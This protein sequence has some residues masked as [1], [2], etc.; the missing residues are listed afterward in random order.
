MR[1]PGRCDTRRGRLAERARTGAT[2]PGMGEP[3]CVGALVRDA[4][5][6]VFAH[7]RS[8]DRRLY[9]GLWDTVGGHIEPGETPE[10]TLAR[11]I[12]EETGWKLRRVEAV[13]ADWQWEHDGVVRTERDYLVEVDGDLSAPR[14]EVGKHD[15]Y[16]WIGR[17]NLGLMMAGRTDGD[18]RLRDIVA[19]AVRTRFTDR[20]RLDPIGPH[21]AADLWR[22]HQQ[23]QVAAWF[24]GR[25]TVEVALRRAVR[26]R[27]GWEADGVDKWMAYDRRTGELVGRGGVSRAEVNGAPRLEVG[28]T[29]HTDLWGCGYA[30]EIGRAGL[31]FAFDEVGADAVVAYTEVTNLRSRAVM[32]RL[33]MRYLR[34]IVHQGAPFVLYAIPNPK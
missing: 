29:V 30:T 19:R 27:R 6:R 23:P 2:V 8:P 32:E 1:Q 14:L 7:R 24:G 12:A 26:G 10:Q 20:L 16:A 5:G 15:A 33:G 21:N 18:R 22:L 3:D 13:F 28:W 25:F 31:A 11:E 9:P 4:A 17:E 34:E